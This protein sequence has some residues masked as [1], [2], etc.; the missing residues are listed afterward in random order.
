MYLYV[1]EG[2]GVVPVCVA[3]EKDLQFLLVRR[4]DPATTH[5]HTPSHT[6]THH[7][8]PSHTHTYAHTHTHIRTHT[9]TRARIHTHQCTQTFRSVN[10][11]SMYDAKVPAD[12]VHCNAHTTYT[13]TYYTHARTHTHTNTNTHTHKVY[14]HIH[15]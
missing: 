3:C 13:R 15:T 14:T 11:V 9:H 1:C 12:K 10:L 5:H 4:P 2:Q 7:H 8:T 6:I